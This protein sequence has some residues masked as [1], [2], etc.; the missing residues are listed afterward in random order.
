MLLPTDTDHEAWKIVDLVTE[1]TLS[2]Q[3]DALITGNL[4]AFMSWESPGNWRWHTIYR[5]FPAHQLCVVDG[6]GELLGAANGVPL[7]WDGDPDTLPGGYDEVL[8]SV[9]D[10][11][12]ARDATVT[13]LLSV[14]L[15]PRARGRGLAEALLA[16]ARRHTANRGHRGIIIPLRPTGK[17]RYPLIPIAHYAAWETPTG[18]AF[19]PWLRTHL[20][21]GGSVLAFAE[22]SL[23]VRQPAS[24]WEDLTGTRMPSPGC[25]LASGALV[26]VECDATGFVTYAEPNIWVW[27]PVFI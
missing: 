5:D 21:V 19:D 9:I 20:A 25:Y 6:R 11:E 27:H 12:G 8:T 24:R 18:E 22:R 16:E 15:S 14:S 13:C 2:E 17:H 23:V 1:P 4:P 10:G 7:H 26:P 3:V